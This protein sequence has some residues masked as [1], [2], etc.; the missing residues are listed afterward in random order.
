MPW[1]Q[2]VGQGHPYG[3]AT[4]RGYIRGY[5]VAVY[6]AF[7]T[8]FSCSG[9]GLAGPWPIPQTEKTREYRGALD[10]GREDYPNL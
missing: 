2:V 7:G 4:F 5:L 10:A 6:P 1:M 8:K 3:F 9:G